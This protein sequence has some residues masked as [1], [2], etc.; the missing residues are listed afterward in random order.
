LHCSI[1]RP[2][3]RWIVTAMDAGAQIITVHHCDN[4][5]VPEGRHSL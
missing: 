5:S 4:E 2:S 1:L 3:R